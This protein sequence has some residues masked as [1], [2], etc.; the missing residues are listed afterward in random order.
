[1]DAR[2]TGIDARFVY[3]VHLARAPE[4]MESERLEALLL[5]GEPVAEFADG[6]Q[7]IYTAPRPGTISPWSSKA[8]DII[9]ACHLDSVLRVERGTCFAVSR[10]GAADEVEL[11]RIGAAL[12]DRMTEFQFRHGREADILF[13]AHQPTPLETVDLLGIGRQALI[14][15]NTD[16]G[17]ALSEDEIEYLE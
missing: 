17:L 13:A 16:L 3:F 8:T 1:M 11:D 15:A 14:D 5:S 7:L 4:P 10:D 9:R 2:V 12:F 6:T